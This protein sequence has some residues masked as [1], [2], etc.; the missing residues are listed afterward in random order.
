MSALVV[1]AWTV[2]HKKPPTRI[3]RLLSILISEFHVVG[4]KPTMIY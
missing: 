2:K 3:E 1:D 4:A